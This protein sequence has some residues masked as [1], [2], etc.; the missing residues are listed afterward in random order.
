MILIYESTK[1]T[2]KNVF[3]YKAHYEPYF[4]TNVT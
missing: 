3:T 2:S 4:L 1:I